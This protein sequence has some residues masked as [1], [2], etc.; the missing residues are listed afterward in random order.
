[1]IM[2]FYKKTGVPCVINT[3]LNGGGEPIVESID[4]LMN[5]LKMHLEVYGAVLNGKFLIPNIN[6]KK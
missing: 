6:I 1:M 5:F 3:S 2:E 4:D